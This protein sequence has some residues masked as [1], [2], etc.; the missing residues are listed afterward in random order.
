MTG[1]ADGVTVIW[2]PGADS[3]PRENCGSPN[4]TLPWSV[5]FPS[6][7]LDDEAKLYWSVELH[8]DDTKSVVKYSDGEKEFLAA[9]DG[10]ADPGTSFSLNLVGYR[11]PA[12]PYAINKKHKS[13]EAQNR[14]Q[15]RTTCCRRREMR[16]WTRQTT[17]TSEVRDLVVEDLK[18]AF[19]GEV[20]ASREE[21]LHQEQQQVEA[22]TRQSIHIRFGECS[23][24]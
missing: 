18:E 5:Q 23:H 10:V 22:R 15:K 2:L 13:A 16:C 20:L 9:D 12:L 11:G 4:I 19:P 17:T 21:E 7:A 3:L 8:N 24:L 1:L 6:N 14:L